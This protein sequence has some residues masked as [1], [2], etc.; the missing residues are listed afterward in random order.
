MTS[1]NIIISWTY[2]PLQG[3]SVLPHKQY[4]SFLSTVLQLISFHRWDSLKAKKSEL[5]RFS[6]Q[7]CVLGL[8]ISP[9]MSGTVWKPKDLSYSDSIA[10][11]ATSFLTYFE[12]FIFLWTE[13]EFLFK[14][15]SNEF[16]LINR[17]KFLCQLLL[18]SNFTA[19]L[20]FQP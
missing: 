18:M 6:R 5:L 9:L 11:S 10:K 7:A 2:L 8:K 4:S 19:L 15:V 12:T 13:L 1:N 17:W 14:C 3:N 16:A 20:Y